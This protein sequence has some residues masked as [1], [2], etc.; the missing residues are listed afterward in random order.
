LACQP[1]FGLETIKQMQN[2]AKPAR[3]GDMANGDKW[4]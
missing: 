4:R 2:V 3:F 1:A